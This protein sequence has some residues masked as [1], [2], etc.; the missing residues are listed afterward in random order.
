MLKPFLVAVQFLTRLPVAAGD[1]SE[2]DVGRSVL[3]YPLVGLFLGLALALLA[4]ALAGR[5]AALAA[6]LVLALWVFATGALHLDAL[7]DSADAWLGGFGDP[8]KTLAIMKDAHCGPAA[9]AVVSVTLIVKFAALEALIA[10]DAWPLL[11][12]V[13]MIGRATA[14]LLFLTTAYVRPGGLGTAIPGHLPRGGAMGVVVMTAILPVLAFGWQGALPVLAGAGG[15]LLLRRLMV[16]RIGG[17]T[18]DTAGAAIEL[19]ETAALV[20]A[21]LV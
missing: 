19:T 7:A 12:V 5:H 11:L 6:A 21:A 18:G 13:P 8:E 2:Q 4:F 15:F 1:R 9:V 10:A 16:K 14:P 3:F 20:A 17:T